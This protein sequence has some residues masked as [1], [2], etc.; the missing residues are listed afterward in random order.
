MLPGWKLSDTVIFQECTAP[1]PSAIGSIVGG[2][3]MIPN[4]VQG[5]YRI[6]SSSPKAPDGTATPTLTVERIS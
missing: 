3:Q 1:A 2:Q 6:V 5:A 4:G